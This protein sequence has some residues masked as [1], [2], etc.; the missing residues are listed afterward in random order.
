MW[1]NCFHYPMFLLTSFSAKHLPEND[2]PFFLLWSCDMSHKKRG[3]EEGQSTLTLQQRV[4]VRRSSVLR[5]CPL[6]LLSSAHS[7]LLLKGGQSR[8][9]CQQLSW[10]LLRLIRINKK[11]TAFRQLEKRLLTSYWPH[12]P[13]HIKH[14]QGSWSSLS[15]PL[16]PALANGYPGEAPDIAYSCRE[17]RSGRGL[18]W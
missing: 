2:S 15:S 1:L 5:R 7:R 14:S 11:S 18:L 8:K 3:Q 17:G 6:L 13:S 10:T 9:L 16:A 12:V 4:I